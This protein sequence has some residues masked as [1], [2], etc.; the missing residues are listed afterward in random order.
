MQLAVRTLIAL[1][2]VLVVTAETVR[3]DIRTETIT[4]QAGGKEYVGYLAWDETIEGARPGVIVVHEWWGLNEHARDR[5][6]ELAS[7]GYTGFAL[8]MYGSGSVAAEPDHAKAMMSALMGEKSA[9][10]ERFNAAVD[11]LKAQP[12]VDPDDIAA[13]GYCMGGAVVL[14]MAR[15]GAELDGVAVFHGALAT[16]QPADPGD[17]KTPIRV[18]TGADDPFVPPEML[19]AF[20]AEMEAAGADVVIQNHA[21]P[22]QVATSPESEEASE[23]AAVSGAA[24]DA[25][26]VIH[27]Y[28]GVVHSF[29]NPA[30]TATGEKFNLP[31]RYDAVA[32]HES[33]F[34]TEAFLEEVFSR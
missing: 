8:D 16:D 14:H 22:G 7:L 24:P 18:F 28:E 10:V 2:V 29:T 15:E 32:D 6:R 12:T 21:G 30:A 25:D 19:A 20:K 27:S 11:A 4:Y 1:A 5:A 13:L 34:A 9:V 3:A 31:L 33:W 17:I 26:V 23:Q